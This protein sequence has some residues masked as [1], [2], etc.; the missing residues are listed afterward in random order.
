MD[1]ADLVGEARSDTAAVIVSIARDPV[2]V[3]GD[4]TLRQAMG[5]LVETDADTALV[6]D[7]Q[8][9]VGVFSLRRLPDFVDGHHF[10]KPA[11]AVA[12]VI[13]PAAYFRPDE[14]IEGM[15]SSLKRTGVVVIGTP[16]Q[17][18]GV[19]TLQT[20]AEFAHPFL[21][22]AEI[23]RI[24]RDCISAL[25][26]PYERGPLFEAA[27]GSHHAPRPAPNSVEQLTVG[28]YRVI[29]THPSLKAVV[30]PVFGAQ[31]GNRLERFGDLRNRLFHFRDPLSKSEL[32][33][34]D[35][36]RRYFLGRLDKI[37]P[38]ASTD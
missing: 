10:F 33:A 20:V 30:E 24:L 11:D 27:L 18:H 38:L 9:V 21:V 34:L 37:L 2:L 13:G 19:L 8:G 31:L 15:L 14:P 35:D 4:M 3:S 22:V 32:Q 29:L 28:D 7:A 23:E 12:D 1:G 26:P 36:Q 17:V 5:R 6:T 25:V 16:T